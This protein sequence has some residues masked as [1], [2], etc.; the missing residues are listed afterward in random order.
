ML[1]KF[2]TEYERTR[3]A[4]PS[5]A[6]TVTPNSETL[7][8]EQDVEYNQLKNDYNKLLELGLPT[9]I[10]ILD[11]HVIRD[12]ENKI[13]FG[14]HAD[15]W[16]GLWD[17]RVVCVFSHAEVCL[18]HCSIGGAQGL[19]QTKPRR[20]R[21]AGNSSH[22]RRQYTKLMIL[23]DSDLWPNLNCGM[24]STIPILFSFSA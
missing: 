24:N 18:V 15:V 12:A 9:K 2:I 22:C 16:E 10:K 13:G 21:K 8:H 11:G 23:R 17:G 3:V 6:S 5:R 14:T 19:S 1:Q 7:N 4:A 20:T